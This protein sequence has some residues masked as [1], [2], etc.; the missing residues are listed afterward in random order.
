MISLMNKLIIIDGSS[1]VKKIFCR[2]VFLHLSAMV[3][4]INS[5][6]CFSLDFREEKAAAIS[7]SSSVKNAQ[8][9]DSLIG[10]IYQAPYPGD[11]QL[12]TRRH[13]NEV[14]EF[15]QARGEIGK[16]GGVLNVSSFGSGPKT[17]NCWAASDAQSSGISS[18]L[19]ESLLDVDPWTAKPYP[20]LARSF[21]MSKDHKDY[22]FVLRKG[23]RWSDG[24]PLTADDVVY[25]FGTLIAKGFGNSSARDILTVYGHYPSVK[26]IDDL[27]ISFHTEIPFAPFLS[28]LRMAIAP[29]HILKPL[30][31][32]LVAQN[33]IAEFN[34]F[35][36][37]NCNPQ[38][39]VG[40]GPFVL[41]RYVPGQ[42]I[43]LI[44]NRYYSMVDKSG[45][46]LPY[47]NK[48]VD[49][50]VPDQNTQLL[51]FYGGDIDL[52]DVGTVRGSDAALVKQKE[53][54]QNFKIYNLGPADG[55]IFLMFNLC[56]RKNP[57]TGKFYVD[58]VKQKWFNN[59]YFRQAV[60]HM[61]DRKRMVDNILRGVGYEL[62]TS[63]T[64]ASVFF[65]KDLKPYPKDPSLAKKLL[66]Q[67]G[68]YLKNGILYDADGNRIEFTLY[69]NAGNSTRDAVC[70]IIQ[71]D[72][73]ELGMK[74]NYQPID[75]N[76][77]VDKC[78]NSLD[79]EAMVMGLTG[80][81]LE[82]YDG[83]NVWKSNGRLHMFDQR[84]P[85]SDDKIVVTDARKWEKEIDNCFD[86]GATTFDI[87]QRHKYFDRYQEI[88]YEEQPFTYLFTNL[89]LSAIRN[90]LGN[91]MPT[92]LGIGSSPRGSM[93]NIEEI[94]IKS[95]GKK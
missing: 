16:P 34:N 73:K 28:S 35:W 26:K 92:P 48:F 64:Q 47:L 18:L 79:W 63:E 20:R 93:H 90:T 86:K 27:T 24:H 32:K 23:L 25:T 62:F 33:K 22:I 44:P 31:D 29:Q 69:T 39:I 36:D 2:Q 83:A 10:N 7:S 84:L 52:L 70:V 14:E 65:N 37:I 87:A 80:S 57:K 45:R 13:G 9:E 8:A 75:F 40:S 38:N 55:T 50:I 54:A 12:I 76:I 4:A 67:G 74:V 60:T 17:F 6:A 91:Y 81:R 85:L 61:L 49:L 15:W 78:S 89:D 41:N 11:Y 21:T 46:R 56:R 19:Y 3:L 68:F 82:P 43:E 1:A 51:K 77:L 5:S 53:K 58:P 95:P 66:E 94:F 88:A 71:N 59:S 30:T 72:L 42:R